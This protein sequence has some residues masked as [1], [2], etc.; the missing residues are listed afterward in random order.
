MEAENSSK[1]ENKQTPVG[2]TGKFQLPEGKKN[3]KF[4]SW[5]RWKKFFSVLN[6]KEK[7]LFWVFSLLAVISSI[8]LV[9]NFYLSH[10]EIVPD[11]GGVFKEGVIEQPRFINP[12]YLSANDTDRDLVE[13]LFSGL[14]KYD[15]Q[16][17][18]VKDLANNYE[19]KGQ[20][21]EIDISLKNNA[22]WHD[23]QPVTADDVLFT[24][25]LIQDPQYQ[26]PLRIEWLGI[27]AEKISAK[28]IKLTI[29]KPYAGFL[30]KL[31]LKIIP[32]HIFKDI[33]PQDFPWILSS[34]KYLI[35]SGPFKFKAMSRDESGRVQQITLERNENYYQ[36]TPYLK[37]IDFVF[38]QNKDDL[39]NKIAS[40]EIQGFSPVSF[41]YLDEAKQSPLKPYYIALPKYF[42]AFFNLKKPQPEENIFSDKDLRKALAMA[43]NKQEIIDKVFKGEAKPVNSPILPEFFGFKAPSTTQAFNKI[44]AGK[45]LDK[46]GYELNPETGKREKAIAEKN[47]TIFNTSLKYGDRGQK[48]RQLQE[49]LAKYKDVYPEGDITGYFGLKT[50]AAVIRFQEKYADEILAPS[51]LKKGTGRVGPSTNTK[52]NELCGK[53][54]EKI[55]PLKFTITVVNKF[56]S[57]QIAEILKE[58]WNDIGAE[59]N[60]REVNLSTFQTDVLANRNFDILVF[61]ESLDMIPDPFSFWHSS[62][63]IYPGQNISGYESKKADSLLEQSRETLDKNKRE[64]YL[65]QFQNTLLNDAPAIFLATNEYPYF[66]SPNI[67]GFEVKKMV[68]PAKRF[69]DVCQWYIKT[70]RVWKR[71]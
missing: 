42:A 61:G 69:S 43:V 67:K 47:P 68:E 16:G 65:E 1:Q 56:P 45:I 64:K 27:R 48:V 12:V 24:I 37:E 6:T 34:P 2:Q 20:G 17:N 14:L 18:L 41:D 55:K 33:A 9:G 5:P 60:I 19:I 28:E 21:K 40:G 39:F 54:P 59:V 8:I 58:N 46:L 11:Y 50:R 25:N 7:I 13:L 62:Q 31:T 32:K 4:P 66:L 22:F 70:K 44:E 51:G 29:P 10:T 15:S 23:G 57:K 38:C 52:L 30:E 53:A 63:K 3:Y 49:C 26:S 35:G 71:K 36:Q